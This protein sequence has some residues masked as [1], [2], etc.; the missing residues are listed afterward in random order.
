MFSAQ[1]IQ[2]KSEDKVICINCDTYTWYV[3]E[4]RSFIQAQISL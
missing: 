1:P 3:F 4:S 2:E